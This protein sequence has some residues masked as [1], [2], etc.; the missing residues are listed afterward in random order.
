MNIYMKR[1]VWANWQISILK[2]S[3]FAFGIVFGAVFADFWKP[4]LW[5]LGVFAVVTSV[6]ATVIWIRGMREAERLEN[7]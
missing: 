7:R 4:L 6:W 3:V 2:L 1:A 5:P